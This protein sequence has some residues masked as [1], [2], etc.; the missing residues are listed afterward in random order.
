LVIL[1][2]GGKYNP[3]GVNE[4]IYVGLAG[5]VV[6]NLVFGIKH[7]KEVY[8]KLSAKREKFIQTNLMKPVTSIEI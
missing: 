4:L 5:L 6:T 7:Y 8:K 1:V 2:S 3:S